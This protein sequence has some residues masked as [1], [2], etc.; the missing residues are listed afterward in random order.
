MAP[1][2]D[3]SGTKYLLAAAAIAGTVGGWML[4]SLS[5]GGTQSAV[6]WDPAI[7]NLLN[8]PLPTLRQSNGLRI[9][10][11]LNPTT[12]ANDQPAPR[13]ALRKVVAPPASA[14]AP[15]AVAVTRSSR[16]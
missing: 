15:G 12:A 5:N 1:K 13:P 3:L 10:P 8:Q 7:E 6:V 2:A 9:G 16:K 4:L 11:V 14:G